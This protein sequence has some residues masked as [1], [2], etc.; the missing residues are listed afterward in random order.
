LALAFFQ[1][2]KVYDS[3]DLSLTTQAGALLV[4]W[5]AGN[6]ALTNTVVSG[7]G[8]WVALAAVGAYQT[9]YGRMFYCL[10]A[11]GGAST[12]S[13]ANPPNDCGWLIKEFRG[14]TTWTLGK[15]AGAGAPFNSTAWSSGSVTPDANASECLVGAYGNEQGDL[16]TWT[17]A[18]W[19]DEDANANHWDS[20]ANQI[21]TPPSGSYAAA[22]TCAL[23]LWCAQIATFYDSAA[24]GVS[25]PVARHHY[26]Q[27][28]GL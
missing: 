5:V 11:T 1:G 3:T 10:S 17:D 26:Q 9:S 4:A 19:T 20:F 21:K 22:G 6:S 28:G 16:T 27:V 15:S 18:N 2:T 8:T 23:S 13:V 7:G 12:F 14:A 25:I 24:G